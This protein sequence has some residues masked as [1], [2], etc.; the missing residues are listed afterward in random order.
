MKLCPAPA[1]DEVFIL[2][3]SA[4]RRLKEQAMHARF[5]Q[6]IE[7]KLGAMVESC[8]K[9]KQDPLVISSGWAGLLGQNTRAAGLFQVEVANR[10]ARPRPSAVEQAGRMARL[11]AA[12]RR[13]LHAAQQ[14]DRLERRRVVARLYS[15]D[16][17]RGRVSTAQERPGDAAGLAS[18]RTPGAGAHPGC[19]L[20][21]CSG[22]RWGGSVA[23]PAWETS[24]EK[25]WLSCSRFSWWTSSCRRGRGRR[26]ASAVSAG[27]PST[28]QF[29]CSGSDCNY[30]PTSK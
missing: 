27:R 9:R 18:E 23:R 10:R 3:R 19:F 30:R 21:T 12:E 7:K 14:C 24:R 1:G 29:C 2:C 26:S 6:R 4:Q 11:G 25:S 28:R 17:S 13:L 15:T 8:R 5:E 22:R 20:R 16:G